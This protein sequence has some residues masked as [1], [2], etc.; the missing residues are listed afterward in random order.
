MLT[1]TYLKTWL[2]I[3]ISLLGALFLTYLPLPNII[4]FFWP[5]WL[6]LVVLFWAL[7]MPFRVGVGIAWCLGLILDVADGSILGIHALAFTVAIFLIV[8]FRFRIVRFGLI[9]QSCT[10]GL[11]VLIYKMLI[12]WLLGMVHA[13]P[14][15]LLY[16]L[17]TITSV[18]L[19]P[20]VYMILRD[21]HQSF[22]QN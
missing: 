9:W 14:V 16:W 8:R 5:E 2:I 18:L 22:L 21:L 1:T 4:S 11:I 7:V 13:A 17:S 3:G 20:W 10:V 19:W 6:L 12:Y 15:S